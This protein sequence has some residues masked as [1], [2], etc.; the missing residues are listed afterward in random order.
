MFFYMFF[1]K[2]N[3]NK[4]KRNMRKMFKKITKEPRNIK[5][6]GSNVGAAGQ[7]RTADLILTN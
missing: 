5:F 3:E 6:H 1:R 2:T 4:A 7:I